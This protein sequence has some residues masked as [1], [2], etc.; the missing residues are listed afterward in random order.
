[1]PSCSLRKADYSADT[2]YH[3]VSAATLMMRCALE[4][5][6]GS[7]ARDCVEKAKSLTDYLRRMKTEAD[8]DL[9]SICLGQC[10]MTVKQMSERGSLTTQRRSGAQIR[11]SNTAQSKDQQ[12]REDSEQVESDL[13]ENILS[14]GEGQSDKYR[15]TPPHRPGLSGF[16]AFTGSIFDSNDWQT[17]TPEDFFFPELWEDLYLNTHSIAP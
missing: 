5:Q 3:F 14:S 8:W 16:H 7:L 17:Q 1:V 13:H 10:E 2:A 15:P 12:A 11:D 9:A 6:S 4:T